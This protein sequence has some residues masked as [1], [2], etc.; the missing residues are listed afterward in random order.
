M[1]VIPANLGAR[2][3]KIFKRSNWNLLV[4]LIRADFKVN[5]HNSVLGALWS[6]IGPVALLAIMYIVFKERFGCEVKAYPLY[7]LIGIV[8][9][10]FFITLTTYLLK[11]V[12]LNRE[13]LLNSTVFPEILIM[14][15]LFS[16]A[17][18]FMCELTLCSAV[19]VLYGL[20]TW[21]SFLMLL[22]LTVAY[23]FFVLGVSLI[24]SLVYCFIR[25]IE[26]IWMI[27][28]RIFF[29]ITP[30]FY[31]VKDISLL[32]QRVVYSANP[33]V[34]FLTSF[35]ALFMEKGSVDMLIYALSLMSGFVF[36]VF[37]YWIF[38]NFKNIAIER[39]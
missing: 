12:A 14:A 31:T 37:S 25:D 24:L 22:P 4:E 10:N 35:R 5:D 3:K 18:K 13:Y 30:V 23:I 33:L 1:R 26:H 17:Y 2:L 8:C 34:F 9:I 36:L 28:S 20:F 19:S 21:K 27:A 16:H 32:A 39:A 29:F 7:L 11:F 6:L 15:R 38:N